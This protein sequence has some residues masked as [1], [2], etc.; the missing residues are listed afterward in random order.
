MA[1]MDYSYVCIRFLREAE[2]SAAQGDDVIYIKRNEKE[3]IW[4]FREKTFAT[5]R[6]T[7]FL[8]DGEAVLKNMKTLLDL[9]KWDTD[10]F[11]SI[12][13]D[14]PAYPS[15]LISMRD[16][17]Q[18]WMEIRIFLQMVFENWPLN[19]NPDHIRQFDDDQAN[20]ALDGEDEEEGE[21]PKNTVVSS[22]FSSFAAQTLGRQGSIASSSTDSDMPSLVNA[23]APHACCWNAH[24]CEGAS[25]R[26][27]RSVEFT[28]GL[29]T[30]IRWI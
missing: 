19:T 26:E 15:V 20:P 17:Q 22:P 30:H 12:Q 8:P 18:A 13:V 2:A 28:P 24:S 1:K 29:R 3:F 25:T 7:V 10:P 23:N 27:V 5:Q 9:M 16:V 21:I 4:N 14:A 11:R 6:Q